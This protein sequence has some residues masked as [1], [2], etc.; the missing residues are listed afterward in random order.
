[1]I[2]VWQM[3]LFV[4]PACAGKPEN[5]WCL[6]MR[7]RSTPAYAGKPISFLPARFPVYPRVCGEAAA[8]YGQQVYPRVCGEA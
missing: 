6:P 2:E 8:P 3:S 4:C 7:R 1:M 5:G